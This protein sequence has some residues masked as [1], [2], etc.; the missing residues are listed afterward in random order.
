MHE[1]AVEV[2][3]VFLCMADDGDRYAGKSSGSRSIKPGGWDGFLAEG[4][5]AVKINVS[6]RGATSV[7]AFIPALEMHDLL[8]A[9]EKPQCLANNAQV[10]YFCADFAI[11]RFGKNFA[12][13][14]SEQGPKSRAIRR[15]QRP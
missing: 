9:E 7:L 13:D 10:L 12:H 15:N 11:V 14:P 8:V 4:I 5:Y 3:E 1:V 2:G 6:F